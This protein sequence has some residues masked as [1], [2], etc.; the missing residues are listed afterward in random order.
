M[1]ES[2]YAVPGGGPA[3]GHGWT[4]RLVLSTFFMA[5]VLE[6]LG[7]G[8][9]MISIG[10]PSIL[11]TFPTTQAG[12]LT[13]AYFLAGAITAPLAGKAADLFGKRRVLLTIMLISG[14]GALMNALAPA[15]GVMIAGRAL[16]GT[17]L[18]TLSLIPSLIRDVYP[19]R[20]VMF[21]SSVVIGGMGAFS[22]ATPLLVGW[23]VDA[24]GFRGMFWFDAGCTFALCLAIRLTTRESP[25]RR[26]ARID[27]LGATL[28]PLGVIGVLL[29]V[30]MGNSWGWTSATQLVLLIGGLV[31]LALFFLHAR[32][33]PDPIINLALFRRKPLLLV[34][35]GAAVAYGIQIT[36][37]T[38]LPLLVLT[39]RAA[40]GNYGLGYST[41]GYAGIG[42]P[43]AL[44]T[45][46]CG[47][48][49][50]F[51]ITRGWHPQTFLMLGL[52]VAPLATM[53]LAYF[54]ASFLALALCSVVIGVSGGLVNSAV[55]S[56]VMRATPAGD[57]GATAGAAQLAQTGFSSI[58]PVIM[59]AI[60]APYAKVFPGGGVV[61][62][63]QGFR[64]WLFVA[65]GLAIVM[66][67]VAVTVLRERRGEAVQE[68]TLDP[69]PAVAVPAAVGSATT[70]DAAAAEDLAAS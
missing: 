37:A 48:V 29:Y 54:N 20:T 31:L 3:A 17:I 66:L 6:A 59:F 70:P 14:V 57:Q 10:L 26:Q 24:A 1:T 16:Q 40:G 5:L 15:F 33:A 63:M 41:F 45:V 39:P 4:T 68:F 8:A 12:W 22:I 9:T 7:L 30:S 38:I 28:L 52:A 18:A 35:S 60:L 67:L 51:L 64:I 58:T 49:L 53:L 27:M 23:L 62:G 50:G 65:T 46:A 32:R 2:P 69:E 34:A 21:A 43:Q 44:A 36:N 13:T 42:I 25:L 11:K 56:L 47:V 61:Y 19:R 55:P